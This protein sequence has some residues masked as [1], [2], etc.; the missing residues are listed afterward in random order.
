MEFHVSLDGRGDLVAR[1]YRSLRDGVRDGRLRP[2]DRLP[3]TRELART[4]DVSRGTVATAY[5]RLTAEGFLVGRVGAGTYVA[6]GA[7]AM[8]APPVRVTAG[9]LRPRREWADV[10]A[11]W[12]A[13]APV[14]YD[15][16]IGT[17]DARLFPYDTWRRLVAAE[18]R[19]GREPSGYADPAGHPDL[20]AAVARYVGYARS[21][22]A[23]AD[24]VVVTGGAQ[25][26]LDL[27]ARV[28]LAPGDVVAVEEPGYPPARAAFAAHGARVV[29]VPVD[30]DGL[31]ISRLPATARLVYVTPSHQFPLG[32]AMSLRRRLELLAWADA[33]DAA[34]V[35][36]DYDSEYRFADRPLEPLH[37]LDAGGRV[38]YVG[39]FSK[40]LLPGLRLGFA[41]VPPSLRGAVREA[42]R[43]A[44]GHGPVA[45]EA[46]LA[47][48]MD[49]GLLARHI[50]RTAKVYAQRRSLLLAGLAGPAGV[51]APYLEAVPS[52]AGLHVCALARPG[53]DVVAV[54]ERARAAGVRVAALGQYRAEAG[55]QGGPDGLVLGYGAI[56]A[57]DV[58]AGLHRLAAVFRAVTPG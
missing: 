51:L 4:L 22:L 34:V 56:D 46:A 15:F 58:P 2:G 37:G 1:I 41:V 12:P 45:T 53:V 36:D 57:A 35:E 32:V 10:P 28:L 43:V 11:V 24:D 5:E 38:V 9:G 17:P 47:R 31:V 23:G 7:T 54:V 44:D 33:H 25:Q 52:A 21:V 3:P 8:G 42:R 19:R 50:R 16:K 18:W 48:F 14:R 13:G 26:A 27:V 29:G 20:R 40:T 6:S 39:T 49:E 55:G 30:G